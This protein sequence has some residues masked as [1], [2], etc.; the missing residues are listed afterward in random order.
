MDSTAIKTK[1]TIHILNPK[2]GK[3]ATN[4]VK[5]N[6]KPD[7][8]I[9]MS[10][11][12]AAT[13]EFIKNTCEKSPDTTFTVYGGDGTVFNAVNALMESGQNKT[14][15]LKVVPVGSGNDF[16]KT[17]ENDHGEHLIDVMHV[18]DKYAVNVINLGFDCNVVERAARLKKKKFISGKM[19]YI[20]GVIGELIKKKSLDLTITLTYADGKQEVLKDKF[21]LC[22]VAN[23]KWYGGGFK[24]APL[25]DVTDG[26]LD[27]VLIKNVSRRTFISFVGGFKSGTLVDE[28]GN[29]KEK[30]K[31]ILYYKKCVS[32]KIEGCDTYCADGE[33][34][35]GKI[36]EISLIPKALNYI[37]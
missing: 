7:E 19:A 37:N 33:I 27:V 15:G 25:A 21:L 35:K 36:V 5:K 1:T 8:S 20:Y 22:A 13:R 32:V 2:A 31:K 6:I 26:L 17:L 29:P 14:A 24:V 10:E 3:G 9:Y 11:T 30:V 18:N 23:A 12:S 28:K 4:K 16:I 34:F